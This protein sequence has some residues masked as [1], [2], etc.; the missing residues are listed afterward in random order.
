M[1]TQNEK[2][3]ITQMMDITIDKIREMGDGKAI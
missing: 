2:A 1:A 3:K